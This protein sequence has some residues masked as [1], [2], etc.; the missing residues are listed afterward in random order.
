MKK[1]LILLSVCVMVAS[2]IWAGNPISKQ[3]V[4]DV[5]AAGVTAR[6]E[7]LGRKS[8]LLING[9]TNYVYISTGSINSTNY[10]ALGSIVLTPVGGYYEDNYY[11]YK[12]T[13]YACTAN[14]TGKLFLLEKE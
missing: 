7:Y 2:M 11:T 3:Y 1:I 9:S 10:E 14:G 6:V 5:T 13:W 4:V 12:S 8:L